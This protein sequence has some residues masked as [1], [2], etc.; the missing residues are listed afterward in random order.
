MSSYKSRHYPPIM[1]LSPLPQTASIMDSAR[2]RLLTEQDIVDRAEFRRLRWIKL[3]LIAGLILVFLLSF[4]VLAQ[5]RKITAAARSWLPTPNL[6]PLTSAF[7]Y[8]L[9]VR[10]LQERPAISSEPPPSK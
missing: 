2:R 1:R 9:P 4:L 7:C 5:L 6:Q 8:A 3:R 10:S